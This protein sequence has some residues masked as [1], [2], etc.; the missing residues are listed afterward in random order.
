MC[1]YKMNN[2]SNKFAPPPNPLIGRTD[3]RQVKQQIY[4]NLCHS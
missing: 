3:S 4:R 2:E 1:R